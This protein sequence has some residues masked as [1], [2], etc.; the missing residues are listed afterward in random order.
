MP[1]TDAELASEAERLFRLLLAVDCEPGRTWDYDG[2]RRIAP[3][4]LE[5][6]QLKRQ[7]NAV[8][9]AHSYVE[10]EI[11]YGVADFRGD[12]Y[13]LSL[14]A[15][16]SRAAMIVFAGVV[17][18]AETAKVLSPAAMVV[19]P[20]RGSGCSLAD[21]LT[22]EQLRQLK[23]AYPDAAVV[24]YINS[25]ADVKAEADVCVTSGNVY[26]IVAQ[27]PQRRIL[28]V[29]DRLMGQNIR[30][31]L[32]RRG[33]D[34]EIVTSDGTCIVHDVFDA[35][36]VAEARA[37]FP[38]LKV[39]A[40]PECTAEVAAAADYVGSTGGMMKYVRET[41]APYFLMLTECGLV[42]RLQVEDPEKRFIGG[43]RLCPYMKLNSLEKVRDALADP[44]SDQIITLDEDLRRRA[45]HSIERMFALAPRD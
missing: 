8:I 36:T 18:M 9:L 26:D 11:I 37:R 12:S 6:N 45:A 24:C 32:A 38:G 34:K 25:T 29:P 21:S 35:A 39:V 33:V 5:I 10:P 3:L 28:F 22:G 13:F 44:R 27:L 31:E 17:F 41:R 40:H 23:A 15:R 20:D 42:G 2:C 1:F 16:E 19:V 30:T 7:K 43:C 4:T 14:K